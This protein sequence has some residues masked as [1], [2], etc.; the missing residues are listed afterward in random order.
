MLHTLGKDAEAVSV[1]RQSLTISENL[2]KNFPYEPEYKQDLAATYHK[3]ANLLREVNKLELAL[4]LSLKAIDLREALGRD[5]AGVPEYRKDLASS[6]FN[7]GQILRKLDRPNEAEEAYRKA[8][9]IFTALTAEFPSVIAYV[10]N[11]AASYNSLGNLLADMDK[12][13]LALEQYR[14]AMILRERLV[15]EYPTIPEYKIDLSAVYSNVAIKLY[16]RDRATESLEWFSKAIALLEPIYQSAAKSRVKSP[17]TSKIAM[18]DGRGRWTSF[19]SSLRGKRLGQIR[20]TE[21][22]KDK[23]SLLTKRWKR[24]LKQGQI[25]E[26]IEHIAEFT[27]FQ[28]RIQI[29]G[30]NM[31]VA[32]PWQQ[33]GCLKSNWSLLI[34]PSSC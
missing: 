34:A 25:G 29:C 10:D 14:Q 12:L 18:K 30:T 20:R 19:K 27:S 23:Y 28:R 7:R 4:E 17:A 8:Q 15:L 33:S 13:E 21:C 5:F 31:D 9:S 32:I 26:A 22:A 24:L 3:M 11:L 1:F 6:H 16:E 2:T